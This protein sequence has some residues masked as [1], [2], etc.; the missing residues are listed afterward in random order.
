MTSWL[1]DQINASVTNQTYHRAYFRESVG[2]FTMYRESVLANLQS[3][4]IRPRHPCDKYAI[5]RPVSFTKDDHDSEGELTVSNWNKIEYAWLDHIKAVSVG[6]GELTTWGFQLSGTPRENYFDTSN[7]QYSRGIFQFSP[8][9]PWDASRIVDELTML[10]TTSRL[11]VHH[12]TWSS[13]LIKVHLAFDWFGYCLK[14]SCL[15]L[16]QNFIAR[17]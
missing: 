17:M 16:H 14:A 7:D 1:S 9:N 8:S 3:N 12:V 13:M 15:S 11:N 5:W 6:Y 4:S 2:F 10:L